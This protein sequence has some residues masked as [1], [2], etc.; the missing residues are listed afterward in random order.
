MSKNWSKIYNNKNFFRNTESLKVLKN[1]KIKRW[2]YGKL[3]FEL[4]KIMNPIPNKASLKKSFTDYIN[5]I[6]KNINEK[7][8]FSILDYGSGNGF[9]LFYLHKKNLKFLKAATQE[10]YM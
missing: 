5:F 8:N 6:Q 10:V 9:T 2:S 3:S 1:S 4:F 7:K